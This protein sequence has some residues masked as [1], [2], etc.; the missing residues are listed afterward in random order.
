MYSLLFSEDGIASTNETDANSTSVF[1]CEI[2]S[3]SD[4]SKFI[5]ASFSF[6]NLIKF[7]AEGA[8]EA[9]LKPISDKS[10]TIPKNFRSQYIELCNTKTILKK[11]FAEKKLGKVSILMLILSNLYSYR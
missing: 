5:F 10:V 1:A 9:K 2:S 6:S 3:A 8:I 7:L 11:K 4:F